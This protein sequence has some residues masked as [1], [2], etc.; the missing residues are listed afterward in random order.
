MT[1][2][3]GAI[4][5]LFDIRF[6]YDSYACRKGKGTHAA[7]D[8][9]QEFSGKY[10]YVLK[11]DIVHFFPHMDHQIL[12]QQFSRVIA[13]TQTLRMCACLWK[14]ACSNQVNMNTP[15]A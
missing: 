15:P 9:A 11:C 4:E 6:I 1:N 12:Y 14:W 13:D 5:P 7:V 3:I 2:P 10:P 8:R